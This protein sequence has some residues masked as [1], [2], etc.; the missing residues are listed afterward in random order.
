MAFA[1]NEMTL[2]RAFEIVLALAWEH[3]TDTKI[4]YS[5]REQ[6]EAIELVTAYF[7]LNVKG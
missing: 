6:V 3:G 2:D 7:L 4:P 5:M 1:E